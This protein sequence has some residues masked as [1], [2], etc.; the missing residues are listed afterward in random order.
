MEK[1]IQLSFCREFLSIVL[2]LSVSTICQ[3]QQ[4][5][6]GQPDPLAMQ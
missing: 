5:R 3:A 6:Q 2:A 1:V 4:F